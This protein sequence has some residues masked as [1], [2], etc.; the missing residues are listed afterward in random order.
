MKSYLKQDATQHY[1]VWIRLQRKVSFV[2]SFTFFKWLKKYYFQLY[3]LCLDFGS[4]IGAYYTLA[5]RTRGNFVIHFVHWF[6]AYILVLIPWHLELWATLLSILYIDSWL[7]FCITPCIF[8]CLD[9]GSNIGAYSVHPCIYNH[10]QLCYPFCTLI[11]T[12][13]SLLLPIYFCV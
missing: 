9:F 7:I 12:L 5:S 10:G 3:Y 8:L 4:N 13:Y 1:L 11:H 6:M 2:K